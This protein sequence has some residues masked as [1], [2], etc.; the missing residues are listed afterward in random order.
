M[1]GS[2]SRREASLENQ[3]G[4]KL[5][6]ARAGS[7]QALG[8]LLQTCRAYLLLVAD[9]ELDADL[10]AKGGASDLVQETFLDAQRNFVHFLGESEEELL[11][12]LRR[13]LLDNL[14]NFDRRY[15]RTAKRNVECELPLERTD[16]NADGRLRSVLADTPSPSWQAVAHEEAQAVERAIARLP[17]DYARIITLIHREHRSFAEAAQAMNR[18]ADA[19]RRLW[20]RAVERLSNELDT[21]HE[22]R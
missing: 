16:P 4:Q 8:E 11:A 2:A 17:D 10:R 12:W 1:P 9:R 15:R 7:G 21:G 3:V 20:S 19:A 6:A 14:S 13:I 22:R 18:S 5:R